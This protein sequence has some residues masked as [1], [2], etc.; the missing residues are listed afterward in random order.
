MTA[1]FDLGAAVQSVRVDP[2]A[3]E[4]ALAGAIQNLPPDAPQCDRLAAIAR[5][6]DRLAFAALEGVISRGGGRRLLPELT[7]GAFDAFLHPES[8]RR[9]SAMARAGP[10]EAT[11][12]ET[13][14][15]ASGRLFLLEE[16]HD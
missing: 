6:V 5:I 9:L 2:G 3:Y 11:P 1:S 15:A 12:A 13:M 7:A 16:Q 8:A 10:Q 14:N 4:L